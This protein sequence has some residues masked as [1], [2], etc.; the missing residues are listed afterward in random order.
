MIGAS[1]GDRPGSSIGVF[2]RLGI[3]KDRGEE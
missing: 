2:G 1:L 3:L